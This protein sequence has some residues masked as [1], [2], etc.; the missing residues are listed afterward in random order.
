MFLNTNFDERDGQFSPDGRWVAYQSNESG[1][2]E[3]YVRPFAGPVAS[4][5]AGKPA[6]GQWQVS[7][8][9]GLDPRWRSDGK[10]LYYIAPE[11]QLMAASIAASGTTLE[12]GAPV[13]L[14]ETRMVSGGRADIGP[15]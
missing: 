6:G 11:G 1:Q 2:Q 9:G 7:T 4:G 5:T 15:G 14:F 12:P 8:A 10:E 13:T 3:I